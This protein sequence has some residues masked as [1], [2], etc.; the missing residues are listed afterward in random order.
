M[1]LNSKTFSA[2][3][4]ALFITA[5]SLQIAQA[6]SKS[7]VWT[8]EYITVGEGNIDIEYYATLKQA[9]IHDTGTEKWIQ[10]VEFEYGITDN[11]DI[12][13]YQ[14]FEAKD[15]DDAEDTRHNGT[16]IETR[17]TLEQ[18]VIP[19]DVLLYAEYVFPRVPTT[20][21]HKLE[22]KLGLSKTFG[23]FTFVYNQIIENFAKNNNTSKQGN[24]NTKKTQHEF[25]GGVFT[26][27]NTAWTY[28]VE[29]T[30]NYTSHSWRVGP[31]VGYHSKKIGVAAGLLRGLNNET[32]DLRAR[33]IISVP[34]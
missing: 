32:D 2:V 28:G 23:D 19:V 25:A 29:T 24:N 16:K 8:K 3:L 10:E 13:V 34:F 31:T 22:L 11:W 6:D 20:D 12:S 5:A 9:D 18:D 27:I 4:I 15:R 21:K 7:L 33:V 17:Y 1:I 26:H 14:V 30:G